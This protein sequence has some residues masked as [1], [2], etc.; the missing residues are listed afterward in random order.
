M[1]CL[2]IMMAIVWSMVSAS[3]PN[4]VS[5]WFCL[6]INAYIFV[7]LFLYNK[8]DQLPM[9]SS[10]WKFFVVQSVSTCLFILYLVMP[11]DFLSS[12]PNFGGL[13]IWLAMF[14]KMGIPPFQGWL[15][16]VCERATW[17]NFYV[18]NV[19]QKLPPLVVIM[20]FNQG[21]TLT[22]LFLWA[23]FFMFFSLK[24]TF[25]YPSSRQ[26]FVFSSIMNMGWMVYSVF[27]GNFLTFLIYFV[28]SILMMVVLLRM[29]TKKNLDFSGFFGYK[30]SRRVSMFILILSL[31]GMPPLL[32]FF[33]KLLILIQGDI[34]SFG[35]VIV[36][37]S[38][39]IYIYSKLFMLMIF[40]RGYSHKDF[41]KGN[42]VMDILTYMS[43]F[44]NLLGFLF[45]LN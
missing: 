33:P 12:Y 22:F 23:L 34:A 9:K 26:F 42:L 18:L 17:M 7:P 40:L 21:N 30:P 6:E 20:T 4:L 2:F 31:L 5:A 43:L 32:G 37:T 13:M 39:F 29:G 36:C 16:E 24:S 10:I 41:K 35:F 14:Y 3:C 27:T 8:W 45:F 1:V 38:L 44:L 11:Y 15:L 28:Y 19:I 25:Y